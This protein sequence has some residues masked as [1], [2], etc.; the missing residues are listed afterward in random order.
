MLKKLTFMEEMTRENYI[1]VRDLDS[2]E[3]LWTAA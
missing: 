3:V 1:S 2:D